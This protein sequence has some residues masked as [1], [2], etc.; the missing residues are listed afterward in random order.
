MSD[1]GIILVYSSLVCVYMCMCV[2]VWYSA[3]PV[4]VPVRFL[5]CVM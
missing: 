4:A 1:E 5:T 3:V 2:C